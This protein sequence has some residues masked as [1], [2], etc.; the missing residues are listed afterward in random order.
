MLHKYMV[1]DS[2]SSSTVIGSLTVNGAVVECDFIV[3]IKTY[4]ILYRIG[5]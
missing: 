3:Q 2:L 5:D 4:N 1:D